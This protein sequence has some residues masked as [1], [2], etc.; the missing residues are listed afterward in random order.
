ML[1][2]DDM[3]IE[4]LRDL[5]MSHAKFAIRPC[6][7]GLFEPSE[8]QERKLERA[9]QRAAEEVKRAVDEIISEGE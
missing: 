8:L 1:I 2:R 9:A 3:M 4:L 5:I 7:G 6:G